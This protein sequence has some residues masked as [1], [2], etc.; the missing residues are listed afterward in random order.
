MIKKFE[1]GKNYSVSP[2]GSECIFTFKIVKRTI[3]N[4]WITGG[5][6]FA[7]RKLIT[8]HENSETINSLGVYSM[9]PVLRA[10]EDIQD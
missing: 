5:R 3:K 6:V 10:G 2:C 9:S 8:I 7:G 4:V 1:V